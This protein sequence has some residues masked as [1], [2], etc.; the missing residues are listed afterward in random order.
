MTAAATPDQTTSPRAG[1]P[2]WLILAALSA[3]ALVA[4]A[5]LW[6][7]AQS[8]LV[9]P[10]CGYLDTVP[11]EGILP[12]P[13]PC[14]PDATAAALVTVWIIAILL[15]GAFV[16]AFTMV[17]RRATVLLALAGAMLLVGVIGAIAT[18]VTASAE[19]PVIY[20]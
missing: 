14:G 2:R 4:A 16:V 10:G 12:G 19:P 20:Y 5:V 18:A 17:R 8:G 3:Y 15:A 1:L 6:T 9:Q 13:Q 7:I 11:P